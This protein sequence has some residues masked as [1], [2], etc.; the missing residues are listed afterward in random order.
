MWVRVC[1]CA[2]MCGAFII[3]GIFIFI[4]VL[5]FICTTMCVYFFSHKLKVNKLHCLPVVSVFSIHFF[6][7]A[8]NWVIFKG[9]IRPGTSVKTCQ[10]VISL[11]Q[12]SAT[13]SI[14]K[15]KLCRCIY[16]TYITLVIAR[17]GLGRFVNVNRWALLWH[18]PT[19]FEENPFKD[20]RALNHTRARTRLRTRPV[21]HARMH[22]VI[23]HDKYVSHV[24]CGHL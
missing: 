9:Q 2:C 19:K 10:N 11:H 3:S 1:V 8:G 20:E 5:W 24:T 12:F 15:S 22:A 21:S 7:F 13:E 6:Y 17:H 14:C 4:C 23:E 18:V 16:H